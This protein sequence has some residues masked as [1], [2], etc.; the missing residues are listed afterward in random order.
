MTRILGIESS[1]DD[2]G[3]ALV[4]FP[5]PKHAPTKAVI[6][7]NTVIGQATLH[8]DFGG[9]VPEIAARAHA[10]TL[11]KA[12]VAS[13]IALDEVDAI[14]V[15]TGP[16]LIGGLLSGTAFASGLS[17]VKNIPLIG[18]NHL[19][20]HGYTPMLTDNIAP[21][22]LMFLVSGGHCQILMVKEDLS[23]ERLGSTIDDSPGEAFD[24]AAKM[25]GLGY[26]GGPFIEAQGK[27]GDDAR[28]AFPRPLLN[29]DG[30]Q[31]SFSGLKSAFR[32]EIEKLSLAQGGLY[33]QDINDLSAS[34]EA[35]IADVLSHRA[36]RALDYFREIYPDITPII[37]LAGGV[38]A[39][40]RIGGAMHQLVERENAKLIVPPIKLCTDNA[41]MIAY[42]GGLKYLR[43]EHD[44]SDL[45][46]RPRW[47]LDQSASPVIGFGK[48]GAKA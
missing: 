20:G 16:G 43:G 48:K 24:K 47:P 4:E 26:P 9:V 17:L 21:P 27:T 19:A 22:Y 46:P 40:A 28:F 10:E 5:A 11:D 38:A 13:G 6:L 33:S 18:V 3:I 42:A 12:F 29:E 8:A 1:C 2:T 44:V 30:F 15:T 7:E 36:K 45:K 25:L 14:A 37:A 41:A 23:F 34:F 31:M 32:R 35:A 39:N